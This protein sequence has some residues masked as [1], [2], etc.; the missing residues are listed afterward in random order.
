MPPSAEQT[1]P[2]G[3]TDEVSDVLPATLDEALEALGWD[4][5][6]RGALG[7][8][9]FERFAAAKE[10]EWLA[11]RRHISDWEVSSYLEI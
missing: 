3:V 10:Q 1:G 2:L 7:Q 11:Y 6:V 5:V 4:A 9:V 8:P